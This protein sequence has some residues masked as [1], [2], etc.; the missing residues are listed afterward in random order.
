MERYDAATFL[1]RNA[2][3]LTVAVTC[4]V[5]LAVAVPAGDM[6]S[7]RAG[8]RLDL[9]ARAE[10]APALRQ[11]LAD[12]RAQQAVATSDC[13]ETVLAARLRDAELQLAAEHAP[14]ASLP[15]EG[16]QPTT[17]APAT[18]SEEPYWRS[19]RIMGPHASERSHAAPELSVGVK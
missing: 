19:Q 12:V 18:S 17:A 7:R 14:Y 10:S 4:A 2:G 5:S 8:A 11:E 16:S 1:V 13:D 15:I 9:L 3:W 6:I